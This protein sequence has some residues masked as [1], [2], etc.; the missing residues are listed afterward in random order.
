MPNEA[1]GLYLRLSREDEE[2]KNE[3]ESIKN[4]RDFLIDYTK[5]MNWAI[6]NIYADDGYS[7]TNFERP[8]FK[9]L[10]DDIENRKVN[11]VITKDLSRLGRDYIQTGYYLEKYFPAMGVRFIAVNDGIDTGNPENGYNDMGPFKSVINDMY[12]RDISKKVRTALTTKKKN[13]VFIGSFAPYGYLKDPKNSGHL[14]IDEKTAP[15]VREIYKLFIEGKS[16][17]SI[18]K[19]LSEKNIETPSY[20]LANSLQKGV[21]ILW[22]DST[23]RRI[24]TN[25]TYIGNLTQNRSRKISYKVDKKVNLKEEDWIIIHDTHDAII[26]KEDFEAAQSLLS[27]RQYVSKDL[28][29]PEHL[30]TGLVFCGECGSS[31]SFIRESPGRTYLVCSK[32]RRR[33]KNGGCTS[34]CIREDLLEKMIKEHLRVLFEKAD[35]KSTVEKVLDED[36]IADEYSS[37]LDRLTEERRLN[38]TIQLTLYR[39]K[40]NGTIS[41]EQ[42]NLMNKKI[43]EEYKAFGTKIDD[44][45]SKLRNARNKEQKFNRISEFL[46]LNRLE[47]NFLILLI[48]KINIQNNK[49]VEILF[50][51]RNPLKK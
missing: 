25:E 30:L 5:T 20:R 35:T 27:S 40:V 36:S 48:G 51:F 37:Q 10:I 21:T 47:R 33:G 12:A 42:Y 13:G 50:N 1:V 16:L 26:Q 29:R 46:E 4:Q 49:K 8:G 22:S 15:V 43:I 11:T 39:D 32:W 2:N 9:R 14:I 34:H 28:D 6:Y 44:I 45:Q 24:L 19:L 7:G 41:G 23:V 38:E 18:A 3:S 17:Q 31:M